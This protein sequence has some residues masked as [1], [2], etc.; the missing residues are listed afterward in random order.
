LN[1]EDFKPSSLLVIGL[2]AVRTLEEQRLTVR[3][4]KQCKDYLE[5]T[6]WFFPRILASQEAK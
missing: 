5:K 2:L 3:Y 4:G 6:R 1:G